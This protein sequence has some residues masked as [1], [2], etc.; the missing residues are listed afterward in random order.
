MFQELMDKI[1]LLTSKSKNKWNRDRDEDSDDV[2]R[3]SHYYTA[4]QY[5]DLSRG[6]SVDIT[7]ASDPKLNVPNQT[8]DKLQ[9]SNSYHQS[10]N[11]YIDYIDYIHRKIII[12]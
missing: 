11:T 7:T 2:N 3:P 5:C 4:S 10:N 6:A 1:A 12:I 9:T 8:P